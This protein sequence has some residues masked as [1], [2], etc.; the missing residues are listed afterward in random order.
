MSQQ[1]SHRASA[2]QQRHN[3]SEAPFSVAENRYAGAVRQ[4]PGN[5]QIRGADHKIP[6]DHTVVDA[7]RPEL[8]LRHV[9]KAFH[10]I[11]EA[12]AECEMTARIES[13]LGIVVIA[14]VADRVGGADGGGTSAW[15]NQSTVP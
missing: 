11:F 9:F 4:D 15:V 10:T 1:K 12:S 13:R 6:M 2:D 14:A 5:V 8:F 7:H 3:D